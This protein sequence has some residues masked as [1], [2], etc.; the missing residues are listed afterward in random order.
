M[1]KSSQ[2]DSNYLSKYAHLSEIVK[3]HILTLSISPEIDEEVST[4]GI[5]D[6][7]FEPKLNFL[8]KSWNVLTFGFFIKND[9]NIKN[10]RNTSELKFRKENYCLIT[11][12]SNLKQFN[13]V[14]TKRELLDKPLPKC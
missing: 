4:L 10:A 2:I 8:A 3:E 1:L 12:K 5:I 14:G 7:Y 13:N 6:V 9:F 11:W